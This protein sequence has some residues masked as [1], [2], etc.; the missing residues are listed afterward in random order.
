MIQ[1]NAITNTNILAGS[2]LGTAF[3]VGTITANSL[4]NS[5][6][7]AG[8]YTST[9][10]TVNAQGLITSAANGTGGGNTSLNL[11]DVTYS[12]APSQVGLYTVV[13]LAGEAFDYNAPVYLD[14][15][16]VSS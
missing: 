14:G 1:A 2:L 16:T 6:V 15:T 9:N 7:T 3:A 4:G 13:D 8:S 12:V 5:G 11:G 10:I